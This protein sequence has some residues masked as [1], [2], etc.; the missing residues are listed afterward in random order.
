MQ[1]GEFAR[2]CNTKISI[3]RHYDKEGL[4]L[5][6]YIDRFSGY[7]YYSEE[8]ISEF[9]KITAL[10]NAGF[11]LAE[12]K[13]LLFSDGG[14]ETAKELFEKKKA[15]LNCTLESLASA[16]D[17][18]LT[19]DPFKD[20]DF[21]KTENGLT[22]CQ[23][24]SVLV[25]WE[26]ICDRFD[27]AL[28][29][30]GYQRVSPFRAIASDKTSYKVFCDS[31][32]LLDKMIPVNDIPPKEFIDDPGVVG[33]WEV[34]GEYAVKED[35]FDPVFADVRKNDTEKKV[36]YF[37]PGGK[38]YW[39]YGWTRSKLII[40]RNDTDCTVNDYSIEELFGGRY[41]FVHLKSYNYRR[42]G[43]PTVLVLRQLDC[44]EYSLDQ[45]ARKDRVDLPFV[46]DPKVLGKWDAVGFVKRKNDFSPDEKCVFEL[47]YESIEFM[48]GG[49]SKSSFT[50]GETIFDSRAQ[51]WTRGYVLRKWMSTACAYEIRE[52]KNREYLFLEWKSGDYIYG[53]K[54]T[55]YYVFRRSYEEDHST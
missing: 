25:K 52:I 23:N 41:M 51:V 26:D 16:E 19:N 22:V 49:L 33:K 45:L 37:L 47:L 1:I 12:I 54:D 44:K 6:E 8:Q 31:V 13:R 42:G 18:F 30:K 39:C 7:R 10:K 14:G 5:P 11:S 24:I 38:D 34:M 15:E 3:L 4:L 28:A 36:I 50:N 48:D 46:D 20:P 35:F 43:R 29:A 17:L 55:N 32:S 27:K 21:I 9:F 40:K 2:I 53:H